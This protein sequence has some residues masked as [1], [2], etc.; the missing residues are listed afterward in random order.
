ME[1]I[2]E[3]ISSFFVNL[4]NLLYGYIIIKIIY[5]KNKF[6]MLKIRWLDRKYWIWYV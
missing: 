6:H 3:R 2:D 4:Y 5:A 1:D